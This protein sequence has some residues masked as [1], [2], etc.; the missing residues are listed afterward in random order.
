MYYLFRYYVSPFVISGFDI[1]VYGGFPSFTLLC[2]YYFL[3]QHILY[4]LTLPLE[5]HY[6]ALKLTIHQSPLIFHLATLLLDISYKL[7][8]FMIH[9]SSLM[10]IVHFLRCFMFLVFITMTKYMVVVSVY[11]QI[12][13]KEIISTMYMKMVSMVFLSPTPILQSPSFSPIPLRVH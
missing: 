11:S 13:F 9:Q 5:N 12:T 6:Q 7:Q 3:P 1:I 4:L 10:T 8:H 2:G